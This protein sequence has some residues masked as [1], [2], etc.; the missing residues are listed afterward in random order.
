MG[1]GLRDVQE[2]RKKRNYVVKD[3]V[4]RWKKLRRNMEVGICRKEVEL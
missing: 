2:G 3:G 4:W 1:N